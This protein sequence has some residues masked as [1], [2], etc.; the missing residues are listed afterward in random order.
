MEP[1]SHFTK[2]LYRYWTNPAHRS[3]HYRNPLLYT[4]K[5]CGERCMVDRSTIPMFLPYR[6]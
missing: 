1:G 3:E 4:F 2:L 6:G 5:I